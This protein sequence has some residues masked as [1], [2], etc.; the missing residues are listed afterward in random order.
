RL[1]Y[2]V[3]DSVVVVYVIAIG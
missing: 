3:R 1:V 2:Q